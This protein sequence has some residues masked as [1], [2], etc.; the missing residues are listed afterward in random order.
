LEIDLPER[1]RQHDARVVDDAVDM[2]VF[3]D[4]CE[5]RGGLFDIGEIAR[6]QFAGEVDALRVP[7]ET[8]DAMAASGERGADREAD[9]A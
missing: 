6:E 1:L 2:V 3:A 5:R 7:R 9:A 8:D 4:P